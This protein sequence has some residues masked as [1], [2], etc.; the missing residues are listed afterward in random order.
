MI[1][2]WFGQE[3][4]FADL[5]DPTD[6]AKQLAA[7]V[8][9]ILATL[10]SKQDNTTDNRW[11]SRVCDC[12]PVEEREHLNYLLANYLPKH[13]QEGGVVRIFDKGNTAS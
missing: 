7:M 2:S 1:T 4:F 9:N 11:F 10:L 12:T 8:K 13:E 5:A 3:S 6:Q